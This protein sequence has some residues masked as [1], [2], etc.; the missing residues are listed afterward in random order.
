MPTD[1]DDDIG[2]YPAAGAQL[3]C[4]TLVVIV[5][6]RKHKVGCPACGQ[7]GAIKNTAKI[8]ARLRNIGRINRLVDRDNQRLVRRGI[9]QFRDQPGLLSVVD[10]APGHDVRVQANDRGKWCLQGPVG[11]R[12]SPR[13]ARQT[14]RPGS[15]RN[16]RHAHCSPDTEIPH[17]RLQRRLPGRR[18]AIIV[19]GDGEDKFRI[20][21]IRT[22]ELVKV[23][24][25]RAVIV[26]QI[27]Q[28]V[29]KG[30]AI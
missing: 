9:L 11:I 16:V 5:V 22:I 3:P 4:E 15:A 25:R 6:S 14:A 28:E 10:K 1:T 21:P 24:F 26:D 30:W 20:V 23:V 7:H 29:E 19:S 18:R 12:L 8:V 13:S 2:D 17:K 27:P